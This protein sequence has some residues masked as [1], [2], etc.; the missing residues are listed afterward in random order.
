MLRGMSSESEDSTR[1]IGGRA[2]CESEEGG[3]MGEKLPGAR[4]LVGVPVPDMVQV[5]R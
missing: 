1:R 4:E 5:Q 3:I 2:L